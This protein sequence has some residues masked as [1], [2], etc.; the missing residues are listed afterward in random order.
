MKY[1]FKMAGNLLM[2]QF[3]GIISAFMLVL[4]VSVLFKNRLSGYLL[5]L[6]ICFGFY[7][8]TACHSSFKC[9]FHDE[10]RA[11][12]D[13]NYR[14]YLYKGAIG[15]AL[16]AFPLLLCYVFYFLTKARIVALYYMIFSMYWTWPMQNI[17]P[18]HLELVMTL[19]FIPLTA[20][21]WVGYI[22]GYKNFLLTD[23]L[24]ELFRKFSAMHLEK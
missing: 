8:Y 19:V 7:V 5:A 14:G 13:L 4:C 18:H 22:A 12:R 9:G 15:G 1:L 23:L 6:L 2:D 21:P 11:R 3:V 10:H 17:F 16:S 20:I 24:M